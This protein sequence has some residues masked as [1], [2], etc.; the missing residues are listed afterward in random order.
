MFNKTSRYYSLPPVVT[1]DAQ[2]RERE[3][4]PFRLLPRLS[5]TFFH[6]LQAVDR[7]DNLAYRYYQKSLHWWPIADANP[8][9]LSPWALLGKE[10]V[11][12]QRFNLAWMADSP[13]SD[14]YQQ[15][16]AIIGVNTVQIVDTWL[17]E[18]AVIITFNSLNTN[19]DALTAAITAAKFTVT[20]VETQ[21]RIGKPLLIPPAGSR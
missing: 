2:G 20:S 4:T 21:N 10:P 7:F 14:L 9:F 6:T 12:T 5:G 3:S 1:T 15:L 17:G 8:E 18:S 19:T 11:I 16:V 13:W